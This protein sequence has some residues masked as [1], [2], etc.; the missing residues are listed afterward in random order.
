MSLAQPRWTTEY[1]RS[2]PKSPRIDQ[3]NPLNLA[4]L[5]A[6]LPL[7][8]ELT[9]VKRPHSIHVAGYST[10]VAQRN[11]E[12]L[13]G[14]KEV[15][16]P[17]FALGQTRN[18]H[19]LGRESIMDLIDE[20]LLPITPSNDAG[21]Y[22]TR[23]FCICGMGGMGKT[24]IAIEY[25][26]TRKSKFDAIIWLQAAGLSQLATDFARITRHL[27]LETAQ[28]AKDLD[29]ST[30][31]AKAWLTSTEAI[32]DDY[33]PNFLLIFDNAD[34]LD[35]LQ[36]YVPYRGN[37]AVLITSRDP[38]ARE[39]TFSKGINLDPLS[40]SE[41]AMLFRVLTNNNFETL[42]RDEKMA[43]Q[44]LADKMDGLP[45]AITQIS[46]FIHRRQLSMREFVSSY[47]DERYAEVHKT[48]T[49]IQDI[50]YGQTLATTWNF[51]GLSDGAWRLLQLISFL[52]P[53]RISERI[54]ISD[55]TITTRGPGFWSRSVYEDARTELLTSSIIKRNV[56]RQELWI[57]RIIQQEVRTRMGDHDRYDKFVEDVRLLNMSWPPGDLMLQNSERWAICEELLPHVEQCY[58]LY[59][60]YA[61]P[62][63]NYVV[64]IS[65]P[66]LLNEAGG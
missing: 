64:D 23:H 52:S 53:D 39:Y 4:D 66:N 60:E 50:R 37:G 11:S 48:G 6:S 5:T 33:D 3:L 46:G 59:I 2:I 45:L 1:D 34:D 44:D 24:D 31:I 15:S 43:S 63:R 8:G 40:S 25:A 18:Q 7:S 58:Q 20:H 32:H 17:C 38:T 10:Q 54:L 42:S 12:R 61:E 27:G 13:L 28:Q 57:H 36:N 9:S 21:I 16:L 56:A 65:F 30:E 55:R 14:S 19:F 41:S 49:R 29:S 47:V 35:V 26:Y 51:Q 62:W 22:Q